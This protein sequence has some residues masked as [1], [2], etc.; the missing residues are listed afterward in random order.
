MAVASDSLSYNSVSFDSLISSRVRSTPVYDD[1]KRM[2]KHCEFVIDVKGFIGGTI[3]TT[4]ATME[5]MKVR[6]QTP[7]KELKYQSR[8]YGN[9]TVNSP[10]GPVFDTQWGPRPMKFNYQPMGAPHGCM[11]EWGVSTCIPVCTDSVYTR[12]LMMS[13]YE[14]DYAIDDGGLT[15]ITVNGVIEIPIT[16]R[17]GLSLPDNVDSYR[18]MCFPPVARGFHRINQKFTISSDRRRGTYTYTDKETPVPLPPGTTLCEVRHRVRNSRRRHLRGFYT[19][20]ISGTVRMNPTLP[21]FTALD[22]FM[23]VVMNRFRRAASAAGPGAAPAAGGPGAASL[24]PLISAV[25]GLLALNAG[26]AAAR[27]ASAIYINSVEITENVFGLD[28]QFAIDYEVNVPQGLASVISATGLW[29]PVG[30]NF[31]DWNASVAGNAHHARGTAM[32]KYTNV[33][34]TLVDLCAAAR[35]QPVKTTPSSPSSS[36][37]PVAAPPAPLST[38]IFS[39]EPPPPETSWLTYESLLRYDQDNHIA[40]HKPLAGTITTQSPLVDPILGTSL[41]LAQMVENKTNIRANTPDITQRLSSPTTCI[42]LV[43]S[44][45]RIG[46]PISPPQLT[47]Y[48]GENVVELNRQFLTGIVGSANGVP[49]YMASWAISYHVAKPPVS[50]PMPQNPVYG[51]S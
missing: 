35:S 30:T 16:F 45:T 32:M 11:F 7:G 37:T 50:V 2:V 33:E 38:P 46:Y 6:L 39:A 36:A 4:D 19:N 1:A 8:G 44:A 42:S 3:D 10:G 24:L 22:R 17:Q 15:T 13:N 5:T 43:G 25:G 23:I 21:K 29:M 49:I 34:D 41:A 47:K 31:D 48:A 26:P 18:H 51:L 27:P 20:N 12:A 9:L 14:V 28:S 40:I